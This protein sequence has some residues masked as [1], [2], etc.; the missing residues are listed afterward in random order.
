MDLRLYARVLWRFRLL[1]AAGV[2][3]AIALAIL[4]MVRISPSGITYRQAELWA[5]T[6]RLLVT[7]SGAPE[8]R[9]YGQAP[10]TPGEGEIL[11]PGQQAGQLGISI[12]DPGRFNTL[13]ILY[14]EL[15]TSDPVRALM[16]RN[17]P[18][19]GQVLTTPLRDNNSG[20]LLPL[21]DLTAISTSPELAVGLARRNT[22]AL[23]TYISEQQRANRVPVADRVVVQT[24]VEPRRV[25]IF[26]PRSRT[27]PVVVFL[28]VMFATVG[29]AFL[30][31]NMR[32][33]T[34]E[35]DEPTGAEFVGA[36]QRRT[37]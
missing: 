22:E 32:P 37:A 31:E 13:A 30:F 17:G 7:Q 34:R 14:A 19:L 29:L 28:I 18:I 2:V 10:A 3:V 9:L 5:T 16:R 12:V 1:V 8:V 27:M 35:A 23:N 33:R 6:T 4:S 24:I 11:S 36:E 26:Q 21:I 25:V 20:I 15:A